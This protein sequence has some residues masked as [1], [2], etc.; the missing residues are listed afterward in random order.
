MLCGVN[1]EEHLIQWLDKL[2]NLS[3]PVSVFR[4]PDIGNSVTAISTGLVFDAGRKHFRSLKLL[5]L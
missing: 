4:E 2:S 1:S 5:N 3:I